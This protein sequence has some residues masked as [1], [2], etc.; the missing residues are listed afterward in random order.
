MERHPD[1]K[2]PSVLER[3]LLVLELLS[4][5][6]EGLVFGEIRRMLGLPKATLHRL[7]GGLFHAGCLDADPPLSESDD[8]LATRR[9][10]W[11]GPRIKRL[12][13]AAVSPDRMAAL[14]HGVLHEL[15]EQ[16]QETAFLG[17]LRG[18][19]VESIMMAAPPKDW[20]G[21]VNPG[22]VMPP[23]AAASAKAIL[24]FQSDDLVR[25]MCAEPLPALTPRTLTSLSDVRRE[26]AH[27]RKT[28]IA[29]CREEIDAGL[30][31]VAAPVPLAQVGVIFA[32][33][34]VGPTERMGQH[35]EAVLAH[36]LQT[37]AARLSSIYTRQL[38]TEIRE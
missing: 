29:W 16:F 8:G 23:H 20:Y 19:S 38:N 6:P 22:H 33:S 7:L 31:A 13:A 27:V 11:L 34:V 21:Y 1:N 17:M 12:L 25:Q 30:I 3:Q 26:L 15:M 35:D 2:S 9:S 10:Y 37:A 14:S 32:V 4:Q 18:T 5:H 24:A 36:A 28:G